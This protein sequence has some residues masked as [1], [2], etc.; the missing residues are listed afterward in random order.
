[1]SSSKEGS[2][3]SSGVRRTYT[4]LSCMIARRMYSIHGRPRA[5]SLVRFCIGIAW[6]LG[7]WA[8]ICVEW[9]CPRGTVVGSVCYTH[10]GMHLMLLTFC[11]M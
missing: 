8:W 6:L 4:T 10:R 2:N 7:P 11:D 9:G 1:M 5:P 3:R